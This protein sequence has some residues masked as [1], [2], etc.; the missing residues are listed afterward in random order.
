MTFV[1][2][3][4]PAVAAWLVLKVPIAAPGSN[5]VH[6]TKLPTSCGAGFASHQDG[7]P[8]LM[9][10]R[11][12]HSPFGLPPNRPSSRPDVTGPADNNPLV[13]S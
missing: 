13:N 2:T 8:H 6:R 7:G 11:A 3:N 12:T 4:R 10:C 5:A 1:A 9:A